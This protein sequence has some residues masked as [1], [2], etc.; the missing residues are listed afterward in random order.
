[1]TFISSFI[2]WHS[3]H[4]S[5]VRSKHGYIAYLSTKVRNLLSWDADINLPATWNQQRQNF[6]NSMNCMADGAMYATL[7]KFIALRRLVSA[8]RSMGTSYS[9][10]TAQ[11]S[12]TRPFTGHLAAV[13]LMKTNEWIERTVSIMPSS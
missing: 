8:P 6:G 13:S 11:I 2:S 3:E 12:T 4:L 10:T 1:M 7:A 5:Q 9:Q